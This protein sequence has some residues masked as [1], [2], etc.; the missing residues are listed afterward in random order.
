MIQ[1]RFKYK[2]KVI[3]LK[4]RLNNFKVYN[5]NENCIYCSTFSKLWIKSYLLFLLNKSFSNFDY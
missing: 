1:N 4:N 3:K 5:E 2:T